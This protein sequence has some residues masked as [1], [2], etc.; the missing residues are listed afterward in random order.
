MTDGTCLEEMSVDL[1][2]DDGTV[3][4]RDDDGSDRL[5]ATGN[6]GFAGPAVK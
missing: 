3:N 2:S 5:A 6:S 4:Q 1:V